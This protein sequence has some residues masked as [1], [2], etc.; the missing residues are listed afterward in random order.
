MEEEEG[1][2]LAV[3]FRTHSPRPPVTLL[4]AITPRGCLGLSLLS[5]EPPPP[6]LFEV[7]VLTGE[8]GEPDDEPIALP[9]AR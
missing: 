2:D 7:G 8:E 5:H 6:S 4:L 1:V 3:T 9:Q